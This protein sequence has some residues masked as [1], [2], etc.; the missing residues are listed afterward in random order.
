M[1]IKNRNRGVL[2]RLI[3]V[4]AIVLC[5]VMALP[6]VAHAENV[7]EGQKFHIKS[8]AEFLTCV[9]LSRERDTSNWEVYLDN[10]I[11]LD[12]EDMKTI[13]SNTVK[14]LSFGNKEHPFK[15]IFDGQNHT[16]KGL[17]Y[18]NN[19]LDP[20]RDTGF[21]A[22]T[23]G[24]TIKNFLVKDAN[25]WAD[26]RGGI[27]VGKAVNTRFENV[28]VMESTLHVT[29]ANNML[30]VIT[31]AG[32]E[33]GLIAGELDGCTLYNCEVRGG[34]A[35]NNTTSGVQAIGGEGLYMAAFA[36]YVK[37]STIEYCRVTP[38]R[39]KDGSIAEK[40]M[41][42]VTNKYDVAIGALGGNN[43]YA[44]GFV[45]CMAGGAK[46]IDCFSTA[47][48][49]SYAASYVGV[50]SVT[51]AW[52]GGLAG[53]ILTEEGNGLVRSHFAG[54]L[55]SRQY[56]PIA[57]IPIIQNDVNLGG[58]A[59]RAN[60]GDATVT[61]CYFKPSVSLKGNSQG[62]AAKK[63]IPSFG[64]DG[65][66]KGD[67]YGPW[68]DERYITRELWEEHDYDFCAGTMRST[69]NDDALGG[70]HA[71][72]WAMDYKLNIPVHGQSVKATIDFPGAGT[73]TI[74]A[75]KLG[76]EQKTSDPY[77][78]AVSAVLAG[79]AQ[80]L[81]QGDTSVTFKQETS[82]KPEGLTNENGGYR[83]MG[84]FREPDVRVNRIG[85]DN[86]WF[87]G[88]TDDAAVRD[89]KRV[90]DNTKHEATS[91]YTADNGKDHAESEGFKGNDLFIAS[92][93]A[94]VL[95][96]NVKGETLNW[97][98]GKKHDNSTDW[99]RYGACL[100]PAAPADRGS[101]SPTATFIGWTTQPSDE[102]EMNGA[103]AAI[104]STK[105]TELKNAGAFYPADSEIA[106]V[107]PTD[108]YPVYS[109][110][111][112]NILTEFEGHEQDGL[113]DKTRRDGVGRTDV[114]VATA[115]DGTSAY[116]VQVLDVSDKAISEDGK[117]PKGY[118][119]LG[120][121]ENKQNADGSVVEVRVSR[122]PSYTL[123]ASVDLTVPHTY[124]ARFEYRVD[125]YVC[126]Y[127]NDEY[128][129]SELLC[130][131]WNE[132]KTPFN[133]QVGTSYVRE[134]VVHWGSE[135][136]NHGDKDAYKGECAE[137][138][139]DSNTLI[140][141]PMS[142]YSHNVRND[143]G[144]DTLKNV[145]VDTDFPG[146]GTIDD[147]KVINALKY[148]F[149]PSSDRYS[150][151]FWTLER[152]GG[153][154]TY[155]NNPVTAS[156]NYTS[157]YRMRAMVT[158][159]VDFYKRDG[160]VYKETTRRYESNLLQKKNGEKDPQY[161]YKY[162][163]IYT[164]VTVDNNS[165]GDSDQ[166]TDPNLTLES[167]P[168]D[169]EMGVRYP[170]GEPDPRYKFLG[171]ISTAEVP[172]DSTVWKYI[173]DVA[174]DPYVTSDPE[175]AKPYLVT[176]D[177]KVTQYQDAYPVYAKYDV[178][179]TTNLYRA[180]FKGTDK[181]N[182]PRYDIAPVI[183]A[184]TDP[185]TA[186]VTPD[187]TTPVYKAGGELYKLQK[188]EIELPNGKV[189][190]LD[191]A[192][193]NSYSHQVE[194]GGAYTF[195]AYYSPLAVVY[196][197]NA[198]D[199]DGKVAQKG[200]MLGN[201][202]GGIP[203]PTY[204][205]STIDADTGG[206]FNVFVGWTEA[207]PAPGKG[208]VAWSE[209]IRMVSASTVVKAP[210]EL[211]PVYR[212][213]LVTVQSNIDSNLANPALVRG[214]GRTDSGDQISLEVKAVKEVV[215]IDGTKYDFVGWSR[216][217]ESDG[218]YTLMTD[219]EK[220]PLEGSE[221]FESVT[222]TAV[223][224]I[225]PHKVRY[226][227]VDGSVIFTAT[228]DSDDE[229]ATGAGFVHDVDVPKMDEGGNPVFDDKG[230]PVMEQKSVAYDPDAY[231][232][233]VAQL[234]ERA[235]T[236]GD[237]RELFLEWRYV[238]VDG[239]AKSWNGFK[240]EPITG[241]MDLYPVT[242]RVTANDTSDAANPVA[243]TAKLKW[244]LDPTAAN[245]VDDNA[246]KA[247]FKV[248]FAE[249]FMGTQLTVTVKQASYGPNASVTEEPVNGKLV[250]L[251]SLGS[252]NGSFDLANRLDSKT[253]GEGEQGD[254]NAVFNF[255]QTHALTV[256]KKTTDASAMGQTFRFK[257]TRKASEDSPAE[258]RM[259][260]VKVDG[261]QQENGKTWYVGSVQFAAS[262]G[263]YTVEEDT[264]WAWRYEGELSTPGKAPGKS[265]ELTISSAS[266]AGDTVV[267]CVNTRAKDKWVDGGS[268]AKNV[269]E[270]GTLR[271]ED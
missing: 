98:D 77:T 177:F 18:A 256:V 186:T 150:L 257:V 110:Y 167:S 152:D 247:P 181:V 230:D 134:N 85:Q 229:R 235:A 215:G 29:C 225:A 19:M 116:T 1:K 86:S 258:T 223:Y 69:A 4:A 130:S 64:G 23:D 106:V 62:N 141:A 267:T 32:F 208:Y 263:I 140:V 42:D 125:Y 50:V 158:T 259:V 11:E 196:H 53:R 216:D 240:G 147:E 228:V 156:I 190:R 236:S 144:A 232:K 115:E 204:D 84:W 166:I 269:W 145:L 182:V 95:F 13:V 226:H 187:V 82:A 90:Q 26:F 30:N 17:D 127:A 164:D 227:G 155:L 203:K 40:G 39:N 171:W 202:D 157:K 176:D 260:E 9:A 43:V 75:T 233:I 207:Q 25:I 100:T 33:G 184:G 178:S 250:S 67:S 103:Y 118:R 213:S 117:L 217:Y 136:V 212:P 31:N 91:I 206:A 5:C 120:W 129:K 138:Y 180:G 114:K 153:R 193:G 270:N 194:P 174:N 131:V 142:A 132:Y 105:L 47:Q 12:G 195:V 244:L 45:G 199:V 271:R 248:C 237:V 93:E 109:D 83:F 58:I 122:D 41:T 262:T 137:G 245:T 139:Y 27:I 168:T 220:Y 179:Y 133:D 192:D 24:A 143:T 222:Y 61:E 3:A 66:T 159:R 74:E 268:R 191:S 123:P 218:K 246:D 221:P 96:Y 65:T 119:F 234:D 128:T 126:A 8:A 101:L 99:Y 28:M 160:T 111:V 51:R 121:Y 241:D 107:G 175:K 49:Y 254:G 183:N 44:S 170:D 94:Q 55:S 149:T 36:G 59:A 219:D 102:A 205:V 198:K 163:F 265:A 10:D 162:P 151:K 169:T 38:T 112:S 231:S 73:A 189:E 146:S 238:G 210:M 57:V 209:G 172:K 161:T 80:G 2:S 87:D 70:S 34:R 165:G 251:Y 188:V 173:Y 60:K 108:F 255:D 15:G 46:I 104:T 6:A 252:G 242:Y 48:C 211:Y 113:D 264:A 71:N 200:D 72:E 22:E 197:L 261:T 63:K 243:M 249:P 224:K 76:I 78:F 185:A 266:S 14:H 88:K 35:V 52:T 154:W 135:H 124:T 201:L 37:N 21:F 214:L 79:T 20:E 7:P 253:T 68:D 97:K 81:A 16:V 89:G 54:D 239:T 148:T 92:Y 56:N